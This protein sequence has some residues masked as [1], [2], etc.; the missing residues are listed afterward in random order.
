LAITTEMI[1]PVQAGAPARDRTLLR[2]ENAAC[3][4]CGGLEKANPLAVGEDFEYRC[5][6]DS[7][8]VM[9]CCG[10]GL[11]YLDPRPA[12]EELDRLYGPD[13][14]AFNF[15]QEG[16]GIVYRIR[17]KLEAK[18]LL[19]W[20]CDL[21]ENARILDVGCGDG[22]HLKL[23]RTYGGKRWQ[24]EGVDASERA[25]HAAARAGIDVHYGKVEDLLLPKA[26][27][28]LVLLIATIEHVADPRGLLKHVLSLLSVGG[29]VVIVTD[30]T[31]TL[32]FSIFKGRH[33]GG[34][35]FPRHWN[36]FSRRTLL[37][38]AQKAG[39]KVESI[40]TQVS[41]VNW[42]YSIRNT[43]VDFE[44]PEW[45]VGL[46][47]LRAS[48]ALSLFTVV[49]SIECLFGNGALL[50]AVL[51]RGTEPAPQVQS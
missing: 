51:S 4:I 11:V 13:Y 28:D 18:R 10:C 9:Q 41:P 46:F 44:F 37:S 23:L 15:S 25:V 3:S 32:D 49:N 22:F 50:C 42:V 26:S 19:A 24:L 17:R 35:H 20:C 40:G 38:L 5:S 30:S 14:H 27:Y 7:F 21:P 16:Y 34:Y 48:L 8:L 29:R 12:I 43:L 2:L 31:E 33:W 1:V 36:L 45:M 39:F 6:P 47:S